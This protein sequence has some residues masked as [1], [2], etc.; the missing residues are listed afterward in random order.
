MMLA[1]LLDLV[2]PR[3][4]AGCGARG[5]GVCPSC[6]Y[7]VAGRARWRRPDPVP[8]GLPRVAAVADHDGAVRE[9]L[10]AHKDRG[11]VDVTPVLAAA[12]ARS[13]AFASGGGPIVLVPVPSSARAVRVR[14]YDHADLL[15]RAAARHLGGTAVRL[16]RPVRGTAD[17]AELGAAARAANLAGALV[18]DARRQRALGG[19]PRILVV[20]DLMTTGATIS[21]AARALRSAGLDPVGAAVVA[22]RVKRHP[23][24]RG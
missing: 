19:E 17:Q 16:L 20:D 11:R 22:A 3:E 7:A 2:C 24:R 5:V 1:A 13:A 6:R 18:V 14:G 10:I 15:A 9:L 23:C 21:E 8:T 12:L 4:C